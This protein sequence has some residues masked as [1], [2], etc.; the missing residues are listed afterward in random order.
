MLQPVPVQMPVHVPVPL[1]QP[2][3]LPVASREYPVGANSKATANRRIVTAPHRH[4]TDP[5][6]LL[7]PAGGSACSEGYV[8]Q[9][10]HLCKAGPANPRPSTRP[11]GDRHPRRRDETGRASGSS[12][13]DASIG[14]DVQR[15]PGFVKYHSQ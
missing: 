5:R 14:E 7:V 8:H 10:R 12:L 15:L 2:A 4:P 1:L 6:T 9:R 3:H 11:E 13:P